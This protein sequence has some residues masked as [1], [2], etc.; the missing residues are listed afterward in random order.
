MTGKKE[1]FPGFPAGKLQAVS[2]PTLFFSELVPMVDD[3]AELKVTLY[4][5]WKIG[6][7]KRQVDA[8]SMSE[9]CKDSVLLRTLAGDGDSSPTMLCEALLRAVD[10][11]SLLRLKTDLGADGV[12]EWYVLNTESGRMLLD[13]VRR[14]E[15]DLGGSVLPD[16]VAAP[17]ERANVFILYE[18]N[19][20][21]LQPLIVEELQEAE[22]LYPAH[23]IEEAFKLAVERNVRNW[24]YIRA[25][26]ERWQAEGKGNEEFGRDYREDG[27][28]YLTGKY[29]DFIKH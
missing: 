16:A 25:I 20:G 5:F 24:R 27:R 28:S 17:E 7:R 21:L 11:G 6:D 4:V 29:A 26:L 19:I 22:N 13:R 2:L 8:I 9:L 1:R 3:L 14:G 15:I 18:Q 23:W 12:E 10:R